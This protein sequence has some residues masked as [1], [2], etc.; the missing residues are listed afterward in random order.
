MLERMVR[1]VAEAK[2]GAPAGESASRVYGSGGTLG[3]SISFNTYIQADPATELGEMSLTELI[4]ERLVG[5]YTWGS[6]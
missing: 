2:F 6:G 1:S 5:G 3:H 4:I